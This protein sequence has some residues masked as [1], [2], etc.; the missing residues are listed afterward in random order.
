MTSAM[1]TPSPEDRQDFGLPDPSPVGV[2]V[3]LDGTPVL[4]RQDGTATAIL[5]GGW[6]RPGTAY[7][8]RRRP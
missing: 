8:T 7:A 3:G 5:P 2:V 6:P 1:V 4:V